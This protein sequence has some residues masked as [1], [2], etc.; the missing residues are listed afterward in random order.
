MIKLMDYTRE[1]RKKYPDKMLSIR[2]KP[3]R[4]QM[5]A[6]ASKLWAASE[7]KNI[8]DSYITKIFRNIIKV[9]KIM[10]LD[11]LINLKRIQLKIYREL[12]RG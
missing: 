5:K 10:D 11:H 3:K 9:D 6:K 12:K 4:K 1:Y 2:N 7:R 8:T